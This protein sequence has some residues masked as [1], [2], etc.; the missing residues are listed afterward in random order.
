MGEKENKENTK[1]IGE[2]KILLSK[3]SDISNKYEEIAK[4]TGANYNVF[5]ILG[6]STREVRTHSAF[7]A[8]LLNP[9]GLHNKGSV[10]LELFIKQ[11]EETLNENKKEHIENFKTDEAS[12]IVEESIG[13]IEGDTGGRIDIVVKDNNNQIVI[14]NKI[15]AEDQFKQLVRYYNEY[16]NA[17]LLYLTLYKKKAAEYSVKKEDGSSLII[18]KDYFNITYKEDILNWLKEC[19]KETA[20][21]P[22]LRET[23][24][25]YIYLIKQLTGQTM[26]DKMNEEI[27]N[28]IIDNNSIESAFQISNS[29]GSI[30]KEL[31]NDKIKPI[32]ESLGFN[33]ENFTFSE[34]RNNHDA[35]IDLESG[36]KLVV[37]F[38]GG[39]DLVIGIRYNNKADSKKDTEIL[40]DKLG[41]KNKDKFEEWDGVTICRPK[42]YTEWDIADPWIEVNKKDGGGFKKLIE[43]VVNA[44]KEKKSN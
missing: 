7:I 22:I 14:E 13:K 8:D 38:D 37:S 1:K 32:V 29:L 16:P 34:Y 41:D 5:N 20:N 4:I 10:F 31:F 40:E 11:V 39:D 25:Q 15:Y 23:L 19:H 43:E 18:D 30:K 33:I 42:E 44:F 26:I 21:H 2:F 17:I 35:F 6:L 28:Y 27:I 9:K 24:T 12:V 3:V 36:N